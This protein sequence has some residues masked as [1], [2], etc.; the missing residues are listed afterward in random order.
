[1]WAVA[2]AFAAGVGAAAQARSNG[3]LAVATGDP[4]LTGVLSLAVG[5][6]ILL[7][8]TVVRA[9]SRR[10]LLR[11]LPEALRDRRLRWW[12]LLGGVGGACYIGSQ[13]VTVPLIG[14]AVFTVAYVAS[15]TSMSLVVD[16][17]G[18][19][20][21]GPRAVSGR[22]VASAA[23]M[24]AAVALAVS[25]RLLS[26]DLVWWAVGA[27]FVAGAVVA[28][29][30]A[31]NGTVAVRTGDPFPAALINFVLALVLLLA[32]LVVEHLVG[33][34]WAPPPAPWEQ[35]LL[36]LGGPTGVFYITVAAVLVRPLGVLLFGLLT[37][38]G[39]LTGSLL[40]DLLVPTPG[41]VVSWQLVAGVGLA[42]VAVIWSALPS[43]RRT[44]AAVA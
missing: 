34:R 1:L 18:F 21:A 17:L 37:I 12:H 41:T 4:F 2:L 8:I 36:W 38:S 27:V 44:A 30:L 20:P 7:V 10:A 25:G 31:L 16:R 13:A 42:L 15:V 5:T 14:V 24:T 32:C 9:P 40:S 33:H 23:V 26:G 22:R 3:G 11:T 35:P 43:R 29:Q 39:Q 28:T 19:G 6:A